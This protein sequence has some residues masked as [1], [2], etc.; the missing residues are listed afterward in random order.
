MSAGLT[1]FDVIVNRILVVE[2]DRDESEFLKTFLQKQKFEVEIA[3]DAGQAWSAC[4]M[5]QPDCV[6]VEAIL[7]N[8][9]SGFEVAER[10]KRQ[11]ESVPIVMLTVV[12]RDDARALA[13]RVGIDAFMTKPY[14][15]DELVRVIRQAAEAAWTRKH[16][17]VE[18][19]SDDKIRFHCTGCG[20]HLKAK[21]SLRGRTLNCP[22][23]GTNV[24]IPLHA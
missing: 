21:A 22:R 1:P 10:V 15:P 17:G 5:H 19:S 14:D 7:Q 3:K 13:Q 24:V 4:A 2:S 9:V 12:D 11:N 20:K 23:C 16:L 8:E 18:A 6:I